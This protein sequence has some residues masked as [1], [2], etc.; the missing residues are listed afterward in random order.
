MSDAMKFMVAATPTAPTVAIKRVEPKLLTDCSKCEGNIHIGLFFDGTNN[1]READMPK[2]KH[3]NVARLYDAYSRN[4]KK[5]YYPRY[6]PGVGTAFPQIREYGESNIGNGFG[7]GCEQRVLFAILHVF[8][9]LHQSAQNDAILITDAQIAALC[10]NCCIDEEF[11]PV[12]FTAVGQLGLSGGLAMTQSN[13]DRRLGNLK[14]LT[15]RL[16]VA[17]S[18]GLPLIKECFVDVFGFSR[19][20]AEARVFCHWLDEILI[21]GT[22]AGVIVHFRFLGIMDT[23]ASAG[24]LSSVGAGITGGE[25]GHSGWADSH[26]LRIPASVK[27]CVH[28]IA[29][30]ELRK[31]FP[32]DSISQGGT[33]PSTYQEF[34]Y[35]GAHSDVGGGYAPGALGIA[36]DPN[37]RTADSQKLAQIPLNHM[38]ACAIAAG[39]PMN[40]EGAI[41]PS[42]GYDPFSLSSLAQKAYDDFIACSTL[43][44]RTVHEWLQPYLTWRWQVRLSYTSLNQ[45]RQAGA[46]DRELLIKYNAM[47]TDDAEY[48]SNCFERPSFHKILSAPPS[49]DRKTYS[50]LRSSHFDDEARTVLAIAKAAKPTEPR[51]ADVFDRFVHDSMAGFDHHAI[52]MTGYWRYRKGYLGTEKRLI[53]EN[54]APPV[55]DRDVA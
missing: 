5:G 36:C 25:G 47:L 1:N 10:C 4:F 30:H 37:P 32:L 43:K 54:N 13:S 31:N 40:R 49:K 6:I 14:I 27:N 17:V 21:G 20:A 7:I 55:E 12:D 19:G 46:Q 9:A 38:L 53:V 45:V 18:K 34:I 39:V 28:M 44:P 24:F 50:A 48:L 23:V 16:Q 8:N 29:A 15:R 2:L 3:S 11:N 33:L 26:F 41:A 35:P 51:L 52:E 22:L 42:T